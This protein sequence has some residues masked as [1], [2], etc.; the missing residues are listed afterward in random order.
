[1]K[2]NNLSKPILKRMLVTA[3]ALAAFLTLTE[4]LSPVWGASNAPNTTGSSTKLDISKITPITDIGEMNFVLTNLYNTPGR[5]EGSTMYLSSDQYAADGNMRRSGAKYSSQVAFSTGHSWQLK[6][7]ASVPDISGVSGSRNNLIDYILTGVNSSRKLQ[8]RVIANRPETGS[9]TLVYQIQ[10]K[11]PSGTSVNCSSS[12]FSSTAQPCELNFNASDNTFDFKWAGYSKNI[13]SPFVNGEPVKLSIL[14]RASFII[15]TSGVSPNPVTRV[16]FQSFKYTDYNLQLNSTKLYSMINEQIT[17]PV[18]EGHNIYVQSDVNTGNTNNFKAHLKF[19]ANGQNYL[20][21]V[22]TGQVTTVNGT[23]VSSGNLY[24]QGIPFTGRGISNIRFKANINLNGAAYTPGKTFQVPLAV[25]DDYFIRSDIPAK[26]RNNMPLYSALQ[27]PLNRKI[28]SDFQEETDYD[29]KHM[30][31]TDQIKPTSHGWY[32][33]NVS[34]VMRPTDDFQLLYVSPSLNNINYST[35]ANTY[36]LSANSAN[37]NGTTIYLHGKNSTNKGMSAI[38]KENIKIDK[39]APAIS[40]PTNGRTNRKLSVSDALS[41]VVSVE[42]KKP[43]DTDYTEMKSLANANAAT[44]V[45]S[46]NNIDFALDP[47]A[48][49]SQPE[50]Y[51]FRCK[52]AAGNYSNPLELKNSAPVVKTQKSVITEKYSEAK[53]GFSLVNEYAVSIKDPEEGIFPATR[54]KWKIELADDALYPQSFT[55]TEG[56]GAGA[57]TTALPIG[58][59]KVT[60][61]LS[62]K[63]SDGN[64]A[65][66]VT[67]LLN[68]IHDDPPSAHD[69]KDHNREIEPEGSPV[70]DRLTGAAQTSASTEFLVFV[71]DVQEM[72]GDIIE[73]NEIT[74]EMERLYAFQS[75]NAPFTDSN[76][77][78]RQNG[79]DITRSGIDCTQEGV[80]Q[81]SYKATDSSGSS[82]TLNITY[83]VQEDCYVTF[84]P[85]KGTFADMSLEKTETVK[86]GERLLP[87]QI[88]AKALI[89]APVERTFIG[90]GTTPIDIVPINPA[91]EP[92]SGNTRLYA[93]YA[94]DINRDDVDD[95]QQALFTFISSDTDKAAFKNPDKITIGITVEE[96]GSVKLTSDKIPG[97]LFEKGYSLKGWKT[98]EDG[99][100][101]LK[102]S[103]LCD[104][105]QA[106]GTHLTCTSYYNYVEPLGDRDVFITFFSSDSQNVPI[107]GGQGRRLRLTASDTKSA[108]IKAEDIPGITPAPGYVF[109]GWRTDEDG[110]ALLTTEELCS[111]ELYGG[112][113]LTCIAYYRYDPQLISR[114]AT[115][116]FFSTDPEH[117]SIKQ[118]EG[119]KIV[120]QNAPGENASLKASQVPKLNL[121]KDSRFLGWKTEATED[122]IL[123]TEELCEL[124]VPGG[125]EL[126]CIAYVNTPPVNTNTTTTIVDK[127]TTKTE[128]NI[129]SK[130][131]TDQKEED[132]KEENK[133]ENNKDSNS[134]KAGKNKETGK[135]IKAEKTGEGRTSTKNE[136]SLV[137]IADNPVPLGR[138]PG[139]ISDK[140]S[141]MDSLR[142]CNT[143]WLMLLWLTLI[144]VT[145]FYRLHG[146]KKA[147]GE[148]HT[149]I[150]DYIFMFGAIAAGVILVI[151]GRCILEYLLLLAGAILIL[152]FLIRMK[153]LDHKKQEEEEKEVIA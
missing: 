48:D 16:Q 24:S 103:E 81:I 118:G 15:K 2:H 76:I 106:K 1:M 104:K 36:T 64:A 121:N 55:A 30:G 54:V 66:P 96:G 57:L 8:I 125:E 39:T 41:G 42:W 61:T 50:T 37:I 71:A 44:G 25:E 92:I 49:T 65:Q 127:S 74:R 109:E 140:N 29:Y 132:K 152:Y 21:P 151:L 149:D 101:I 28:Y 126:T 3:L 58:K 122:R 119:C 134:K 84:D 27:H 148:T 33:Q 93:I 35:P 32:N 133:T 153:A 135:S 139:N 26:W 141:F 146:R 147:E 117:A 143:H 99:D 11:E 34:L 108:D 114:P 110:E 128:K 10:Q 20:F 70:I 60:Y 43:G 137:D 111:K 69:K 89:K 116:T 82:V 77:T 7:S 113:K 72:Y 14:G 112:N 107:D 131:N 83:R 31:T 12:K 17:G 130:Q 97:L 88:P 62:G 124:E 9:S 6:T 94:E 144:A 23:N 4:I 51:Y 19:N 67:V 79:I 78:V 56:T 87:G 18:G 47:L 95:R 40:L 138:I 115:F 123:T 59:Y 5:M 86:A 13:K 73:G 100:K 150:S 80:Y 136:E 105:P 120:T 98:D 90:W 145:E 52:D 63:D 129:Y 22:T 85:G 53:N 75:V 38:V 142:R 91:A 102:T 46:N 45:N 68:I